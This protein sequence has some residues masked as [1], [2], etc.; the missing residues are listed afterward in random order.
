MNEGNNILKTFIGMGLALKAQMDIG[1][2]EKMDELRQRWQ[3][4]RQLPRK[5]K[6]AER[7]D[8][9]LTASILDY[10]KNLFNIGI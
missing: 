4:S 1:Y 2:E 8:I 7:K 5:K 6:K 10:G 3:R 9:L